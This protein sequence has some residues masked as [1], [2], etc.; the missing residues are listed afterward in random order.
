MMNNDYDTNERHVNN[1]INN[2]VIIDGGNV[3]Q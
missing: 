1:D 3:W 2:F